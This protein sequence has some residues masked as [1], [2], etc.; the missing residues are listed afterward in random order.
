MAPPH[1][2]AASPTHRWLLRPGLLI[3]SP[4]PRLAL[5]LLL[6]LPAG[7]LTLWLMAWAHDL[8]GRAAALCVLV[9]APMPAVTFGLRLMRPAVRGRPGRARP[10]PSD[11]TLAWWGPWP[12]Q[13]PERARVVA[14]QQ[15]SPQRFTWGRAH[16]PVSPSLRLHWGPHLC[17]EVP[18]QG[19]CW[20]KLSASPTDQALKVLLHAPIATN[21]LRAQPRLAPPGV[22]PS[23]LDADAVASCAPWVA[24]VARRKLALQT[25]GGAS[26][27]GAGDVD[28]DPFP[29]TLIMHN[30]TGAELEPGTAHGPARSERWR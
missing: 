3:G 24:A 15:P 13:A 9:L 8:S 26:H 6:G 23:G 14:G 5:A 12:G 7:V 11:C 25:E 28:G 30:D 1:V 27:P 20:V 29:P 17:I 2:L 4:W 16:L 19:W 21:A 18:G 22:R 10:S